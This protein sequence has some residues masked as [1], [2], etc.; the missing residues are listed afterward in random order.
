M[1][2]AQYTLLPFDFQ[3]I[4]Q[5]NI[6]EEKVYISE[7]AIILYIK[8][9]FSDQQLSTPDLDNIASSFIKEIKSFT[10]FREAI[11]GLYCCKLSQVCDNMGFDFYKLIKNRDNLYVDERDM[12]GF[13]E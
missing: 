4:S 7:K 8:Q 9:L 1:K 11:D 2:E 6:T 5:Y 13:S 3:N 10:E 12:E